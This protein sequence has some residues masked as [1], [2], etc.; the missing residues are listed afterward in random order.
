MCTS[1][2]SHLN[3]GLYFARTMDFPSTSPWRPV[4]LPKEYPYRPILEPKRQRT[5]HAILGGGRQID[6]QTY[7]L[8]DGVN[9]CGLV[10][11]ELYFPYEAKYALQTDSNKWNLS[12][13]DFILWVLAN[14]KTVAEVRMHLKEINLVSSTWYHTDKIYP[15]HWLL[16]DKSGATAILE[17]KSTALT[18]T[19]LPLGVLTN[20]PNMTKQ[21]IKL[22]QFL[23]LPP[24]SN[25][26][27][28]QMALRQFK[29]PLPTG[30][31]PTDRFAIAAI[32][33][34]QLTATATT[35][36]LFR[37]L[38]QVI[39]PPTDAFHLK[40]HDYTHYQTVLN[41]STQTYTFHDIATD[42]WQHLDLNRLKYHTSQHFFR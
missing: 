40:N 4:Y 28:L 13:Q 10:C 9:D 36:D 2:I 37:I 19:E 41:P 31:I 39:I 29:D 14:F 1:F 25:L 16:L 22:R 20:T 38:D 15:Y 21:L 33:K 18:L 5:Q 8:A 17:P 42:T 35:S 26:A 6:T 7:L 23:N 24:D 11:A 34:S 27:T 3:N 12:P 30:T 32:L